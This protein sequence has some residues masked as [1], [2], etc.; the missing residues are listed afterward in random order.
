MSSKTN[1]IK[2]FRL[3]EDTYIYLRNIHLLKIIDIKNSD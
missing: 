3:I 2:E 1:R